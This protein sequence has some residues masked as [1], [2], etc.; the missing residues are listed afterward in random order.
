MNRILHSLSQQSP[1]A[2]RIVLGLIFFAR[3]DRTHAQQCE[4]PE[5]RVPLSIRKAHV[6]LPL[7]VVRNIQ[8]S[9]GKPLKFGTMCVKGRMRRA[10]RV[11]ASETAVGLF[12]PRAT[13]TRGS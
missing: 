2:A 6:L 4:P 8:A 1:H 13:S 9:G 12:S 5:S 11:S 3:A 7:L 10:L